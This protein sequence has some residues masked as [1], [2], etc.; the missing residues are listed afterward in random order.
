MATTPSDPVALW[1]RAVNLVK[2]KTTSRSFWQALEK[3]V[4]LA[5]L[6]D[7]LIVG[8]NARY[9]NEAG[10]INTSLHKT[11]ILRALS[12]VNGRQL[13]FRLIEGDTEAD[14]VMTQDRD[15]RVAAMRA[16]TYSRKDQAAA[17]AQGWDGI[18]EQVARAWSAATLRALPQTKARY[19]SDMLYVLIDAI[20]QYSPEASDEATEC[21]IARV[22]DRIAT[23]SEVPATLVALEVERLRAWRASTPQAGAQSE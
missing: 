8:L 6:D 22:I 17:D 23:N 9:A 10:A 1:P 3:T 20:D 2:D 7:T 19:L 14:W 15:A 12:E 21:H 4:A 13:G 18:Y 16:A 5:V 11:A